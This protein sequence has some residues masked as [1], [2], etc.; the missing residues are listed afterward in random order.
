VSIDLAGPRKDER[1]APSAGIA[2]RT[3]RTAA[4]AVRGL[5]P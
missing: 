3:T 5:L 1:A 2:A 4:I